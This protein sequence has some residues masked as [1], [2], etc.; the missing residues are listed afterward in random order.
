MNW[1]SNLR[2]Q[3]VREEVNKYLDA[4]NEYLDEYKLHVEIYYDNPEYWY[5]YRDD[6]T[7]LTR[8]DPYDIVR[9]LKQIAREHGAYDLPELNPN[10]DSWWK[11]QE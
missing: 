7:E 8:G 10:S 11:P 2:V 4:L 6:A 3:F 5:M 9:R 1:T